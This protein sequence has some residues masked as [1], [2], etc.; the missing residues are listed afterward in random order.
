MYTISYFLLFF[1]LLIFLVNIKIYIIIFSIVA[2]IGTPAWIIIY[3]LETFVPGFWFPVL[4]VLRHLSAILCFSI[5][6]PGL[7][8]ILINYIKN[9]SNKVKSRKIFHKY[10]VHEGFVGIIFILISIILIIIRYTLVQYEIFRRE[11]RIF[12]AISMVFLY[13]FL[14]FGSFLIFRDWRDVFNFKL[15]QKRNPV[16]SDYSTSVFYPIT[17]NSIKFFKSPKILLYPFGILLSSIA[18]NIF[19]HGTDFLPQE[20]FTLNHETLV[21]IGI[22]L[23]FFAG[24]IVGLDWYRLFAKIYPKLYQNFEQVLDKLRKTNS[25]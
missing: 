21:L 13:L 16:N 18:V 24:G 11:L 15:I 2:I 8:L 23:S 1:Y 14:F 12:L 20:V 17:P 5:L 6:S 7:T 3:A 25:N 9:N 19:I 22:I 10:H 4:K